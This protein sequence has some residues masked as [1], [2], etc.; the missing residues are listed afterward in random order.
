[1]LSERRTAETIRAASA[2]YAG[3]APDLTGDGF[4]DFV[5]ACETCGPYGIVDGR[6]HAAAAEFGLARFGTLTGAPSA[7]PDLDG[8]GRAD[9]VLHDDVNHQIGVLRS[10]E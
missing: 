2:T 8:D 5:V 7:G 4:T 6:S 10:S 3:A 9:I 1:M